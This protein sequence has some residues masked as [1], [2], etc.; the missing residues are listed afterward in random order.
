MLRRLLLVS[1]IAGSALVMLRAAD[2]VTF[3][4]T[5]GTRVSGDVASTSEA[6][7][8]MPNGELNLEKAGA[9][10][11]SY[12][13][14]MVAVIDFD[15][16]RPSNA[17]LGALPASGHLLVTKDDARH[18]G[19]MVNLRNGTLRWNGTSGR[20]EPYPVDQIKRI[21]L[22]TGAAR[23]AYNYD[24]N[25]NTGS[26]GGGGGGETVTGGR[27][28]DGSIFVLANQAWTDSGLMVRKGENLRISATGEIKFGQGDTQRS[29]ANGNAEVRNPRFPVPALPVGGLIGRVGRS[30]AFPIGVEQARITMPEDGR[31]MLGINDDGFSDNSGYFRVTITRIR[32]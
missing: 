16:G 4:L 11:R 13:W 10:E 24:P 32:R 5:D 22:D 21:Y 6:S 8:A 1:V 31:L 28:P 27:Q 7:P 20:V 25:A 29:N 2:T 26:G 19:R 17:E 3:I 12:G 18:I 30:A 15:G 14:E 9:D 23:R